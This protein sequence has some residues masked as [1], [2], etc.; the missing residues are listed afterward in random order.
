MTVN[1]GSR[2]GKALANV[3]PWMV[4]KVVSMASRNCEERDSQVTWAGDYETAVSPRRR[5]PK[6]KR[7]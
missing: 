4:M 7:I 3:V 6:G 5:G 2:G 1:G